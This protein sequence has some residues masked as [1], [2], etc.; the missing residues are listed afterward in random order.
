MTE[1]DEPNT[2]P[3][4]FSTLYTRLQAQ[5]VLT[6]KWGILKFLLE[7][8]DSQDEGAVLSE[9][10]MLAVDDREEEERDIMARTFATP[11]LHSLPMR[12]APREPTPAIPAGGM[13]TK[14]AILAENIDGFGMSR[15]PGRL[16][17]P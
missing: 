10:P 17:D 1:P 13:Q 2:L 4:R 6:K 7:L 14:A 3:K 15:P 12:D 9:G 8:S 16:V 11:G 5:G